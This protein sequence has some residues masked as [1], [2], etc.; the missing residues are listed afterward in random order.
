MSCKGK[1][2]SYDYDH[3]YFSGIGYWDPSLWKFSGVPL[4]IL[5]WFHWYPI[6]VRSA[7]LPNSLGS[8][9]CYVGDRFSVRARDRVRL[10]TRRPISFL[11]FSIKIAF[12]FYIFFFL[13]L[14]VLRYRKWHNAR[15]SGPSKS[16]TLV[17]FNYAVVRMN[18][19]LKLIRTIQVRFLRFH[20]AYYVICTVQIQSNKYKK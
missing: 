8:K 11:L 2:W 19:I 1:S 12:N 4:M 16:I 15:K 14:P 18:E 6:R 3:D 7:N 10:R 13:S 9:K 20:V 17:L 5:R